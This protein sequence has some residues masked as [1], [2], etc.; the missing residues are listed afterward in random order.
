MIKVKF[1]DII[2]E[3]WRPPEA[4]RFSRFPTTELVFEI[5]DESEFQTVDLSD[6]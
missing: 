3:L 4:T 1:W 2:K 5:N 6:E